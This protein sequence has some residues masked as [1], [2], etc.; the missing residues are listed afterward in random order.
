MTAA[1]AMEKR[2]KAKVAREE[3]F[4]KEMRQFEAERSW[5]DLSDAEALEALKD[6]M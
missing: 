2:E 1:D 5:D 3:A 6:E 4:E